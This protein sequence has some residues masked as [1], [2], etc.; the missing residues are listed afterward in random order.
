MTENSGPD[1]AENGP[2]LL[3]ALGALSR[4]AFRIGICFERLSFEVPPRA[5][6]HSSLRFVRS[7]CFSSE[8]CFALESGLEGFVLQ[9][10]RVGFCIVVCVFVVVS[11]SALYISRIMLCKYVCVCSVHISFMLCTY[12]ALCFVHMSFYALCKHRYVL[13]VL[14]CTYT[15]VCS[16][17]MSVYALYIGLC[18]YCPVPGRLFS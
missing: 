4:S 14:L 17:H 9:C 16:A 8:A 5:L 2:G 10:C 15:A 13:C 3:W 7:R 11:L 1:F 12:I 6:P 18:T